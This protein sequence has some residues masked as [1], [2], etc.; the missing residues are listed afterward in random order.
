MLGNMSGDRMTSVRVF[1]GELERMKVLR[2]YH[3]NQPYTENEKIVRRYLQQRINEMT[4]KGHYRHDDA[5]GQ[6]N[7]VNQHKETQ[8]S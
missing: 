8:G 1:E 5:F 2:T 4:A 6:G 7:D 3:L